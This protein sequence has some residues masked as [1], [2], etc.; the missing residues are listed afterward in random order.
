MTSSGQATDRRAERPMV[1]RPS[2]TCRPFGRGPSS[3]EWVPMADSPAQALAPHSRQ[4]DVGGFTDRLELSR[5]GPRKPTEARERFVV[6]T[7]TVPL[8]S[9]SRSWPDCCSCSCSASSTSGSVSTPG[10]APRTPPEK[11]PGRPP[12]NPDTTAIIAAHP[13]RRQLPRPVEDDRDRD[14]QPSAAP[15]SAPARAVWA[16]GDYI[17]VSVDYRYPYI[18]PLPGMV[19]LGDDLM[20]HSQS[21]VRFEG[22]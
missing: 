1:V 12:S 19:G 8:R 22:E 21:E 13:R 6:M 2:A 17:R 11:A 14:L 15:C 10:T 3:P 9:S 16:E 4:R 7:K 18:T 5:E 20:L